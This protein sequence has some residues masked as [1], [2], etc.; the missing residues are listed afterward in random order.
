[1]NE[2][3]PFTFPTTAQELRDMIGGQVPKGLGSCLYVVEF[4]DSGIKV[5]ITNDPTK[6]LGT[7][8]RQGRAFGRPAK[9]GWFTPPHVEARANERELIAFCARQPDADPRGEYFAVPFEAACTFASRL[10]RSRGD[11]AAHEAKIQAGLDALKRAMVATRCIGGRSGP[12]VAVQRG[13]TAEPSLQ[14][15]T[16]I[17]IDDPGGSPQHGRTGVLLDSGPDWRIVHL[18]GDSDR[19]LLGAYMVVP[20]DAAPSMPGLDGETASAS[21]LPATVARDA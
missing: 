19:W 15:R 11:E 8:Q 16:R 14:P 13:R 6:R 20:D 7:H 18:D 4:Q 21:A 17:R 3:Q 2:I 12:P 9:R 1:V 10:P 5:G